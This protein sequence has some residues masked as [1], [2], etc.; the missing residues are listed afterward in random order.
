MNQAPSLLDRPTYGFAEVDTLLRLTPGTARRWIDGYERHG[1]RYDPV[2]R[3]EPFRNEIV[4]WG[5]FVEARLLAEYRDAGVPM[6][7]LRP[8]VMRLREEF[9]SYP[10]A[11]AEPFLE[12]EG[13]ELVRAIQGEVHLEEP[14]Q[15]VVL[16]NDQVM[17]ADRSRRFIDVAEY[18][19]NGVRV[20][21]R[22]HPL[23]DLREVVFDP[24]RRAGQPVVRAVPT[25][26]IAEQLRAGDSVATIV[27]AYELEPA[28]VEA[29][30]RYELVRANAEAA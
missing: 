8:A 6:Q 27:E 28:Q 29:A 1:R 15:F 14:L 17:L 13:R 11:L 25:D 18:S 21:V 2:V 24:L 3:A 7:R 22:L 23:P 5:E 12:V 30:I 26:V 20:V 10:L 9:G 19:E 16:R 4:T